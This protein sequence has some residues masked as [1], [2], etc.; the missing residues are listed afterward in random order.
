M[1][2][3]VY[4]HIYIYIYVV[5]VSQLGL[6]QQQGVQLKGVGSNTK[7]GAQLKQLGSNKMLQLFGKHVASQYSH[8]KGLLKNTVSTYVCIYANACIYSFAHIDIGIHLCT[9]VSSMRNTHA[10]R[11]CFRTGVRI[12][13]MALPPLLHKA[14]SKE[15]SNTL[16]HATPHTGIYYNILQQRESHISYSRSVGLFLSL[17]LSLLSGSPILSL[18]VTPSLALTYIYAHTYIP[19]T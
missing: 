9:F 19:C 1:Y 2:V 12:F 17:L 4:L 7:Q 15:A 10:K 18:A 3:C 11:R 5:F 8:E 6:L 13:M 14:R 16:Q